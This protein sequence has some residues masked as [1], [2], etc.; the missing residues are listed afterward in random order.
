MLKKSQV[1]KELWNWNNTKKI[2]EEPVLEQN[3]LSSL[4]ALSQVKKPFKISTRLD[5]KEVIL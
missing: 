5:Q 4:W 2:I 3:Y 1:I